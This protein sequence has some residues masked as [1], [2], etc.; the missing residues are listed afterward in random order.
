LS[1]DCVVGVV[2]VA[3]VAVCV[4]AARPVVVVTVLVHW[5]APV[6]ASFC[7]P[8]F[9]ASAPDEAARGE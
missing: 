8:L 1:G 4:R 9:M 3:A 6:A 7:Q 2:V 5:V